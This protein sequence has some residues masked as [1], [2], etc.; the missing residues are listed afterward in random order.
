MAGEIGDLVSQGGRF[1]SRDRETNM[2]M[3]V[4]E[5]VMSEA[6]AEKTPGAEVNW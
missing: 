6:K 4:E 3:S 2:Q 5:T 1:L